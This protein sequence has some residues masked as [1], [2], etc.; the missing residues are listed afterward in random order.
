VK[1]LEEALKTL[2]HV[3]VLLFLDRKGGLS[4][5][6]LILGLNQQAVNLAELGTL[7]DGWRP[8]SLNEPW[9]G[10]RDHNQAMSAPI[11]G[12]A[13]PMVGRLDKYLGMRF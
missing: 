2:V 12:R 7:K 5:K 10:E 11:P 8:Q 3:L 4:R 9:N 6:D 13:N 1:R